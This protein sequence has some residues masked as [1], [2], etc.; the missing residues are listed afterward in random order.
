MNKKKII[1]DPVYGFITIPSEFI[2]DLI[3]HP[4]F[5]RL[6][7]IRQLG[8]AQYVYP[9]AMHT[10]FHHAIGAMHITQI[11][12]ET[13]RNKGHEITATEEEAVSAAI[14]LHDIGHG[15]FSHALEHTLVSHLKHEDISMMIMEKI[16]ETLGGALKMAIEIFKNVYPKKFL[17]QLVSSQLD[18]DRLDYL[19]RDSFFTGVSEGIIS[20]ER[21]LKMLNVFD[22]KLVIDAKGIYSVEKFIVARR[23]MY[24]QVYLHKTVLAAENQLINTLKRARFLTTKGHDLF[25]TKSFKIFLKN[26]FTA[27]DFKKQPQLIDEFCQL[28]DFDI[29]TSI[30]EWMHHDDFLLSHLCKGLIDRNLFKIKLQE[31]PF[32]QQETDTY[33]KKAVKAF[34]ITEE[35]ASSLVFTGKIEN[36]AYT[37]SQENIH[38]LFKDNVIKDIADASDNLSIS[39]LSKPVVKHYL[40]VDSG[41]L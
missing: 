6:R 15:P 38:I 16:N 28:D 26:N 9:G 1:N 20:S 24:W 39:A 33:L 32:T 35:E 36:S 7:R 19:A 12:I 4:Y 34:N 5:Q 30:K 18:M 10:R 22:D 37:T 23:L 41:C 3:E 31:K 13:L 21:I 2:F 14:L 25:G 17:H 29:F 11:A 27:E 8:L 40:C